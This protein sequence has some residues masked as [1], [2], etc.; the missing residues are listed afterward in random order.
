VIVRYF[1][2]RVVTSE[3]EPAPRHRSAE[4]LRRARLD[5]LAEA[6]RQL[7]EEL[8]LLHQELG[9]NADPHDRQP[10]QDVPVQGEPREGNGD[11]RERHPAAD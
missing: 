1:P 4:D 8:A 10:V 7:D 6:R 5:E 9:V 11:W 2:R 3:P